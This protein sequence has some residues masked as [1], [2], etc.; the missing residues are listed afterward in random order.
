M[1]GC[2][3]NDFPSHALLWTV[4]EESETVYEHAENISWEPIGYN[5]KI[6]HWIATVNY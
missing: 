1:K 4:L 3:I 2:F 6:R 5:T